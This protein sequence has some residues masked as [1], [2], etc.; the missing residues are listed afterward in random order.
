[1]GCIVL[2]VS[3]ACCAAASL[4]LRFWLRACNRKADMSTGLEG[5]EGGVGNAFRYA[6]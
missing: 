5:I 3:L 4:V 1:M 2:T 6:L